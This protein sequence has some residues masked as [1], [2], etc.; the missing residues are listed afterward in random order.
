MH[1]MARTEEG[2]FEFKLGIGPFEGW[3]NTYGVMHLSALT[4]AVRRTRD[5][6]RPDPELSLHTQAMGARHGRETTRRLA[7]KRQVLA[8]RGPGQE[9]RERAGLEG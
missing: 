9:T 5:E 4:T 8:D 2:R 7:G 6:M 3:Q 1:L